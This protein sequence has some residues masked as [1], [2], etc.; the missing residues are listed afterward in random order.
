LVLNTGTS[1]SSTV[2]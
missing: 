1:S 2:A